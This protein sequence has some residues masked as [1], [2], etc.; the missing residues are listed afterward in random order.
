MG[1]KLGKRQQTLLSDPRAW[2]MAL[3]RGRGG[4]DGLFPLRSTSPS[5][6]LRC[7][8]WRNG[9]GGQISSISHKKQPNRGAAVLLSAPSQAERARV[10][11][12]ALL[13]LSKSQ[14]G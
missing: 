11:L 4:R 14:R 3:R 13:P 5:L 6:G 2:C 10:P 8:C 12:A 1:W 9:E 7:G